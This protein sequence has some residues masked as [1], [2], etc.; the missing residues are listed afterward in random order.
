VGGVQVTNA[1]SEGV[2]DK[3]F[4]TKDTNAR[5]AMVFLYRDYIG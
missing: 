2:T 3:G 5:E 1:C 4:A